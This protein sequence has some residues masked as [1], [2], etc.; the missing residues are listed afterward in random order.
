MNITTAKL[1][2]A[3][4]NSGKILEI[5]AI[6]SHL[7]IDIVT[8]E[9]CGN[10]I[11]IEET[12]STYFENARIKAMAYLTETGLPVLADDTGL[13]VEALDGA[14]GLHSARF[15]PTQPATDSDRR[16]YLLSQLVAKP[17]PWKA[18]FV[19]TT[20]LALPDGEIITTTGCCQGLI[21]PEERGSR[22]FGY[23]PVFYI[24]EYNATMAE[25][26]ADIKNQISHRA[27]ALAAMIP[28]IQ[29]KLISR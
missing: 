27:R 10:R 25:L 14:P 24:P 19:C 17:Q 8:F 18:R 2:I 21:A 28:H 13:E 3:S 9:D 5:K 22:G 16:R 26:S 12:G 6:L 20:V 29:E 15:S 4:G 1:V 11:D 7:E 23:D